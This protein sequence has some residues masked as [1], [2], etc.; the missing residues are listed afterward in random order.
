MHGPTQLLSRLP[1]RR[2]RIEALRNGFPS[3]NSM[4]QSGAIQREGKSGPPR[5]TLVPFM[6]ETT[7]SAIRPKALLNL[8]LLRMDGR[9]LALLGFVCLLFW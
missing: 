7:D 6:A 9:L 5:T 2:F 8:G 4:R 1:Q 3:A